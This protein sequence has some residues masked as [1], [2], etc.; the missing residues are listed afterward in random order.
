MDLGVL[1]GVDFQA[2]LRDRYRGFTIGEPGNV[3]YLSGLIRVPL[4]ITAIL[5]LVYGGILALF[6]VPDAPALAFAHR[7]ILLMLVLH[8]VAVLVVDGKA[9]LL[10]RRIP[11]LVDRITWR[12]DLVVVVVLAI[13]YIVIGLFD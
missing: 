10:R 3:E 11:R 1:H 6:D 2:S 4:V 7:A 8:L 5:N 9:A 13:A 12:D